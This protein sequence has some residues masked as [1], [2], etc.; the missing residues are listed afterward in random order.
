[1]I[2]QYRI[3]PTKYKFNILFTFS[4]TKFLTKKFK[5]LQ[6]LNLKTLKITI[7]YPHKSLQENV[8]RITL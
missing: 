1:M 3:R 6:T 5:V 2:F 4:R 7:R 8:Y